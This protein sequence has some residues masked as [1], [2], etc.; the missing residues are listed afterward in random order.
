[1]HNSNHDR[2]CNVIQDLECLEKDKLYR[3]YTVSE[4][5][6]DNKHRRKLVKLVGEKPLI[7]CRLEGTPC[8]ALWDTGSMIS[9]ID[10]QWLQQN[11]PKQKIYSVKE[12]MGNETLNLKAAN[13]TN[14][15]IQIIKI[16]FT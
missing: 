5:L 3:D 2:Y 15:P 9:L 7:N 12:F 13:N 4:K 16:R 1:M 8:K 10:R 11:L 14:V 6:T